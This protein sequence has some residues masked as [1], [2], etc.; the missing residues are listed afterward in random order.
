MAVAFPA[1]AK[2]IGYEDW[3]DDPVWEVLGKHSCPGST[4]R[5][6]RNGGETPLPCRLRDHGSAGEPR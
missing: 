6:E 4:G 5:N 3:I 1:L 2:A